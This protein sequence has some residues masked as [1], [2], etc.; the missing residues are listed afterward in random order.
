[1]TK[2]YKQKN[3]GKKT[4]LLMTLILLNIQFILYNRKKYYICIVGMSPCEVLES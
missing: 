2:T 1:M 3:E 4:L